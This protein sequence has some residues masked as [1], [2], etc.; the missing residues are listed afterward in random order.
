MVFIFASNFEFS[1]ASKSTV[2]ICLFG[3]SDAE[4][5]TGL[6]EFFNVPDFAIGGTALS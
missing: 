2:F 1:T 3:A 5:L 4:D 6:G